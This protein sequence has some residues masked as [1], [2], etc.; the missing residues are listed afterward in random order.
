MQN[1]KRIKNIVVVGGGTAGW[2]S[3]TFI[4]RAMPRDVKVTLIESTTLG[5]I[6]V[7]EATLPSLPFTFKFLGMDEE[8]WM[9]KCN[10]SY[11]CAVKFDG[12]KKPNGTQ[13]H[14]YM[15]PFF[16]PTDTIVNCF[17]APWGRRFPDGFSLMHFWL[18]RYLAGDKTPYIYLATP[19]A[20]LC[21][22]K[23]SPR[24]K[25]HPEYETTHGYHVDAGLIV[26]Y[27]RKLCLERGVNHMVGN[28]TDVKLD[29]RGYIKSLHTAEGQEITADLFVDCSGF[30]GLLIN[31]A[32]GTKFVSERESLFCDSAVAMQVRHD[33]E[34]EGL[35]PYTTA[36][37]ISS[38]W[39]W[40]IP[41]YHRKGVGYVYSAEFQ[42]PEDAERELREFY[43]ERAKDVDCKHLKIRTGYNENTFVKNCVA[44]GLAASF[45]EPLESTTIGLIEYALGALLTYFPDRDFAPEL[46]KRYND[47]VR[48]VFTATR[49]FIILHYIQTDRDDTS[50]WRAIQSDTKIPDSL[51]ERMVFARQG[52]PM[53]ERLP[54]PMWLERNWAAIFTGM[55]NIPEKPW[56]MTEHV[57]T[58]TADAVFAEIKQRTLRL[59][60][61]LPDH[62]DYLKHLHYK[63]T[64]AGTH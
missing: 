33:P 36:T 48:D 22:L 1:D 55:G 30:E 28:I 57:D 17:D 8:E 15:H 14:T 40:D 35:N 12:W 39:V 61:N 42:R 58:K 16:P 49:D 23:K 51:R 62:Y 21:D 37:A 32:L 2:V 56:P 27:L 3:A 64:V 13:Q 44:V 25:D 18:K 11:K 4:N 63:G 6:G 20:R 31:K 38:G 5:T 26:Q 24:F 7:G 50:F 41:L 46:I 9:P 47:S 59:E 34:T 60:A 54:N 45:I 52:L 43:G 19:A 10:A 29:E 53:Q